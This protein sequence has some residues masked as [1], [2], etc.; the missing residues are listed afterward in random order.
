MSMTISAKFSPNSISIVHFNAQSVVRKWDKIYAKLL[1]LKAVVNR[2][3]K[4]W[5]TSPNELVQFSYKNCLVFGNCCPNKC[6]GGVL[7]LINPKL[8]SVLNAHSLTVS[9]INGFNVCSVRL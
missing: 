5:I 9:P 2:I 4:S 6:G 8:H 3:S 7:M 1:S